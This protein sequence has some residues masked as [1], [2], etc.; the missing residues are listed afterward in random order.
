MSGKALTPMALNRIRKELERFDDADSGLSVEAVSPDVWMV[1]LRGVE[2][3]LYAGE[4][5][6][7]RVTF[8]AGYPMECAEVSQSVYV[9]YKYNRTCV[10]SLPYGCHR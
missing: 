7:L 9:C 8:D 10:Y 3:T 1:T 2:G 6:T 4:E 5:F